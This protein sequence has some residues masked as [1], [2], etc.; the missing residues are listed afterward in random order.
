MTPKQFLNKIKK[1]EAAAPLTKKFE[2][3]LAAIG[4]WDYE[5][6]K[7]K[8]S[9]QKSHWTGWLSEYDGP[10]FYNR[11]NWE[12]ITAETIYKRIACP[13]MLLWLCEASGVTKTEIQS[14]KKAAFAAKRSF[15]SQCAAIRQV[16]PWQT[17]EQSLTTR[18]K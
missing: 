13:P 8:Y 1:L 14:A 9:D 16:I 17:V 11:K 3:E 7:K 4:M 12:G 6:E 2:S 5:K 15:S 10:G 18:N